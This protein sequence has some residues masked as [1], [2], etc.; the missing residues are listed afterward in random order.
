MAAS[1][2][3]LHAA[4]L[5]A[6]VG[7][8]ASVAVQI[9]GLFTLVALL[10]ASFSW[11]ALHWLQLLGASALLVFDYCLAGRLLLLL[12]WNRSTPFSLGLVRRMLLT[13]PL[14]GSASKAFDGPELN[15]ARHQEGS[16]L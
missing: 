12:P 8:Q 4:V 15:G 5:A 14:Q 2:A 1:I 16:N 10:G 11:P 9:R 6:V 13:Y 3:G 7:R